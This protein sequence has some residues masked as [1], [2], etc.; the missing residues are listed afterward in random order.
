MEGSTAIGVLVVTLAGLCMGSNAWQM[1]LMRK[2]QFEHWWL[3]GMF[4]GLI[5]LPWTV[6]LMFCPHA[7]QAYSNVPFSIILKSNLF[8][9]SWGI[10]NVLC[11][12]CYVRIGFALTGAVLTGLGVSVGVTVPMILK[13]SGLFKNAADIG[14]PA[15]Q[16]VMLGVGVMVVGVILASVAGFG[17]DKALKKESKKSG[18]FLG[19]L[20]MAIIAGITSCGISLAFVYGQGPIVAAM[21]HNGAGV[22][23]ANFAVWAVGLIGGSLVNLLFPI[24]LLFKNKSWGVFAES[25]KEALIAVA[26]GIQFCLAVALMGRGMLFLGALGASVGFGIQQAS[27]MI[28]GQAVGFIS[29][30]WKGIHG[31]PRNLMYITILVLISAAVIMA[32]G[33]KLA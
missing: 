15:G 4:V 33:N 27:Q 16:T 2:Y 6:T 5:V 31:T 24:Y 18:S 17:R 19:G 10:A 12:L 9:L 30:E 13:G 25:P 29:G 8:A 23:P 11:G 26:V 1:K 3:I 22:I 21:Q 7:L 28:G 32:Y 20:I 14:S